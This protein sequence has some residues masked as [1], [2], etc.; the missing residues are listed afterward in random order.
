MREFYNKLIKKYGD[1]NNILMYLTYNEEKSVIS[2][3]FMKT[4]KNKFYRKMT[5]SVSNSHF[6]YLDGLV[7]KYNI[8]FYHHFIDKKLVEAGYSTLSEEI[9]TN[10]RFIFQLW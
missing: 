7:D 6:G 2:E 8:I 10:N 1:E 5:T 3:R 4:Q 9:R